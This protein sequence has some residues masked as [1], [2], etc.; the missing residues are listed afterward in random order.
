MGSHIWMIPMT[1]LLGYFIG[2][3]RGV[4]AVKREIETALMMKE[5]RMLG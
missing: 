4:S 3:W 5:R 2:R 1:F